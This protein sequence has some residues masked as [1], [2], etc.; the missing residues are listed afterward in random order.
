VDG[1]R[2]DRIEAI[3]HEA[4]ELAPANRA[5]FLER[6]CGE[7]SEL[8]REVNSL[9]A[10]DLPGDNL[11]HS[12]IAR[13]VERVPLDPDGD[14]DLIGKRF[15][16]Y[17]ITR[18]IGKGGMGAVYHAVRDDDFHMEAAIKLLKRG[19]NTDATLKRF[20]T[21]RQILANL[22]HPNIARLIDG[23]A[24]EDGL[25]FLVMEYV[26][27]TPLIDY[28]AALSIRK[29]LELFQSVCSAVEYAHQK[30]I[31]HRDIKPANVLVTAEGLPKLLDFGIAKLLDPVAEQIATTVGLRLMTPDYASPEQVLGEPITAAT[32]V[33][34]LGA[35]LYELL[36][37]R[38]AHQVTSGAPEAI[39]REICTRP[40]TRPS[41]VDPRIDADLDNVVMTALRK[42][43]ERRYTSVQQ[44]SDDLDRYLK[45]L[46]VQARGDGITYRLLTMLRRYRMAVAA[47]ATG[48]VVILAAVGL[49][50]RFTKPSARTAATRFVAVLPLGADPDHSLLAD[51]MT[52]AL[53]SDLARI[54]SLHIISHDSVMRFKNSVKAP[55]DIA[56]ELKSDAL[57]QG[58]VSSSG[59][60]V[61][62]SLRVNMRGAEPPLWSRT[63]DRGM[64]EVVALQREAAKD[65]ATAMKVPINAQEQ[66]RLS[67]GHF[68]DTRAYDAYL[69]GR[70][71]W[72]KYTRDGYEKSVHY[73]KEAIEYDPT[74]APA[75]A[76][77]ADAYYQMS[78]K[79]LPANEAMPR[80][81]AAA[82]QAIALD[83]ALPE[84]HATL[85]QIHSQYEWDWAAAEASYTEALQLQPNYAQTHVYYGMYLAEQGRVPQAIAQLTEAVRL[86]PL[87]FS[88]A[89]ML[90]WLNH[91]AHHPDKAIEQCRNILSFDPDAVVTRYTLG[92]AY[93]QKQMFEPAIA[94]FEKAR[95]LDPDGCEGSGCLALLGH[96]YAI[97]GRTDQARHALRDLEELSRKQRVDPFFFGIIHAGLGDA[98][99]TFEWFEQALH[100]RSE[101]LLLLKVDPRLD[102]LRAD[103]RFVSL[104]RRLGLPP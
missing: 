58:S 100:E 25:P 96:A 59:D 35:L 60:R 36:T 7:D 82:L 31:V 24:T 63:Y 54:Q 103:G 14:A 19:S 16:P 28:A 4:S 46:P 61:R 32:D 95:S 92:L 57:V 2:W 51:G 79:F 50:G 37:G 1:P 5:A 94:E 90:A 85:A 93:E 83:R 26:D 18:L 20:R 33:Y 65:I 17:V 22:Q 77:L 68:V 62:V 34:S 86:D 99:S 73:F 27:G 71:H 104:V 6:A 39:Y 10:A 21:E 67:A 8:L 40:A 74:Y 49:L 80:A 75:W 23:G 76:G 89:T 12:A 66:D 11:L 102:G 53:I 48:A 41:A 69:K 64:Q 87:P 13:A 81:K 98:R 9:L 30:K 72:Y 55:A 91:L 56:R 84:A 29:R 70:Y 38:R 42:E 43:P 3:F 44:F 47:G 97:S 15:G 45:S 78:N 52:D 101:E 88:T